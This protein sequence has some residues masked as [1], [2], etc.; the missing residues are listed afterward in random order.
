[1]AIRRPKVFPFQSWGLSVVY[2]AVVLVLAGGIVLPVINFKRFFYAKM[3]EEH[4]PVC[5]VLIQLTYF[6]KSIDPKDLHIFF[7]G[8]IMLNL[9]C[10]P[11][12]A[13][14][15]ASSGEAWFIQF[16][17]QAT[18]GSFDLSSIPQWHHDAADRSWRPRRRCHRLGLSRLQRDQLYQGVVS[19]NCARDE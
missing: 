11:C 18:H 15:M 19:A 3:A 17:Y 8:A 10:Y 16:I 7:N 13:S 9:I 12:T 14:S 1:M 2:R 4:L 5:F 6:T